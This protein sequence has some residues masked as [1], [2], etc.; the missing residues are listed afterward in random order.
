MGRPGTPGKPGIPGKTGDHVTCECN[1]IPGVTDTDDNPGSMAGGGV[2]I[3]WGSTVCSGD[4]GTKLVY[5]GSV[6]GTVGGADH[7]CMPNSPEYLRLTSSNQGVPLYGVE[8]TN[9]S[10][11]DVENHNIPCALC[12]TTTRDTVVMIPAKVNC[13]TNWTMEYNGYL[14]ISHSSN[15]HSTYHCVDKDPETVP[16][17]SEQRPENTLFYHV[18]T[19]CT[20]DNCPLYNDNGKELSC[21]VCSL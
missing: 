15:Q 19:S 14:M 6:G 12:Y 16:G 7:L 20:A 3:H 5:S 2:Y 17:T 8:Y 21:V 13:P 11:S 10:L 4:Q 18:E 9:S 1:G